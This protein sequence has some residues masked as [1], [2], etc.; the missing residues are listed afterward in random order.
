MRAV[1]GGQLHRLGR[2]LLELAR[3][4]TT[5]SDD[6]GMTAGELAVMED[7][8]THVGATVREVSQR[9]GFVQ[10]HV[11]NSVAGLA[12]RGLVTTSI[13]P[14]DRRRTLVHPTPAAV[15]AV[16]RRGVRAIES[17]LLDALI[18]PASAARAAVLLDEL[19]ALL[20]DDRGRQAEGS[21]PAMGRRRPGWRAT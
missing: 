15:T 6:P 14:R 9:S 3:T 20:L 18:N 4:V 21:A 8:L 7:V 5:S 10:S 17:T 11:S 12:R 2:R 16:Q 13:D 19:A 1:D